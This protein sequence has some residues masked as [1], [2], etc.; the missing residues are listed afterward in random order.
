MQIV[1]D[2]PEKVYN[3]FC[4]CCRFPD[5]VEEAIIAISDGTPLPKGHWRL[6]D[7]VYIKAKMFVLPKPINKNYWDGVADVG[8]IIDD[9]PTIIE[10]ESEVGE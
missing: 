5:E 8:D 1:I 4:R 6:K 3:H 7:V 2:I 9:A 10:A